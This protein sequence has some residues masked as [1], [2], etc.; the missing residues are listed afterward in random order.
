MTY[1]HIIN[2]INIKKI[3][4]LFFCNINI[5]DVS[6]YFARR[7]RLKSFNFRFDFQRQRPES[8]N[9]VLAFGGSDWNVLIIFFKN[10]LN[11]DTFR[12]RKGNNDNREFSNKKPDYKNPGNWSWMIKTFKNSVFL[13]ILRWQL[14]SC[15]NRVRLQDSLGGSSTGRLPLLFSINSLPEQVHN[16]VVSMFSIHFCHEHSTNYKQKSIN[17]L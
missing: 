13:S 11:F 12:N 15:A 17:W 14:E 3:N 4:L 8:F 9:F 5:R 16:I 7:R 6:R 2:W 1:C 10:F